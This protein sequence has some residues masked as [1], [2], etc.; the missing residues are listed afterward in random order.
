MKLYVFEG[1]ANEL[2]EVAKNL[3]VQAVPSAVEADSEMDAVLK[4]HPV[5]E[6]DDPVSVK[7]A[8]R[9]LKR[10]QI[11]EPMQAVLQELYDAGDAWV[12]IEQLC[13]ASNYTRQQFAGLM[14]AFGRRVSHT[15]GYDE[16][17]YFFEVEWDHENHG[18][19][20]KIPSS[21]RDA[22][23]QEGIVEG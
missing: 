16:E 13:S 10:L 14:G 8:R 12:G 20:Y 23:I 21:V 7:F 1:S 5:N 19:R 4:P 3:G 9:V 2:S 15:Q 17:T 18:C 11:S 22:L 6:G